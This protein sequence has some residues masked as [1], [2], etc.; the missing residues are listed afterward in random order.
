MSMRWMQTYQRSET[1][2][3]EVECDGAEEMRKRI[4]D[5]YMKELYELEFND[6]KDALTGIWTIE[7][8]TAT[9]SPRR[10]RSKEQIE[11]VGEDMEAIASSEPVKKRRRRQKKSE[12]PVNKAAE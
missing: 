8:P 9:D 4:L 6:M 7:V 1:E 12:K 10:K 3:D 5:Q 11:G 2:C